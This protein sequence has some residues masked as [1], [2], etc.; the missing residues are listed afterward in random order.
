[1]PVKI[2]ASILIIF[3]SLFSNPALAQVKPMQLGITMD[4]VYEA[5]NTGSTLNIAQSKTAI[6]ASVAAGFKWFRMW[7]EVW[8]VGPCAAPFTNFTFDTN[9]LQQFK[10]VYQYAID[11]GMSV[12]IFSQPNSCYQNAGIPRAAYKNLLSA[13][14]NFVAQNFPNASVWQIYNEPNW[15]HRLTG[16][17]FCPEPVLS[18]C[19]QGLPV[20]STAY[21]NELKEDIQIART[22]IKNVIP[23]AKITINATGS[24]PFV[25][26]YRSGI[27]SL[28]N[29]FFQAF[30]PPSNPSA[31]LLDV[32]GFDFYPQVSQLPNFQAELEYFRSIYGEKFWLAETGL[33]SK[34]G[35]NNTSGDQRDY[36]LKLLP[37][38]ARANVQ[39]TIIYQYQDRDV[40]ATGDLAHYGI[41][42]HNLNK[43]FGY[44]KIMA[45][46]SLFSAFDLNKANRVARANATELLMASF[47]E[48]FGRLPSS[49]DIFNTGG[50]V[51]YLVSQPQTKQWLVS[52]HVA[53]MNQT[54][55][56]EAEVI[57]RAYRN[58][59]GRDPSAWELQSWMN[60]VSPSY[61][62]MTGSF[63][64]WLNTSDGTADRTRI[65][66]EAYMQ[67][68]HRAPSSAE[69]SGWVNSYIYSAETLK[70]Q[71]RFYVDIN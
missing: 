14:F 44:E 3:T 52:N 39:N 58:Y 45:T 19:P 55:S 13:H 53:W 33:T 56:A 48:A 47:D 26:Q 17:F 68:L 41:I 8:P 30:N 51:D 57:T 67:Y 2:L 29:S 50:W 7:V 23:S 5:W 60:A 35:A 16:Q 11:K 43:K 1:M 37:I 21:K 15:V 24:I 28:L 4:Y 10:T 66:N 69:L 54:P 27:R 9:E 38:I 32:V 20:L 34:V 59:L 18:S 46:L 25:D 71:F 22:A 36:Y 40:W 62:Q 64:Y 42:D 31:H 12:Y 6:D 70:E 63:T 65:V 61:A 49:W